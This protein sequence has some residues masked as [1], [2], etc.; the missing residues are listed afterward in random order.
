MKRY[1]ISLLFLL[2]KYT[3]LV[4]THHLSLLFCSTWCIIASALGNTGDDTLSILIV[5]AF[6]GCCSSHW[7]QSWT[8]STF[9]KTIFQALPSPLLLKF[10]TVANFPVFIIL[11]SLNSETALVCLVCAGKIHHILGSATLSAS[12]TQTHG[13]TER[14]EKMSFICFIHVRT[15]QL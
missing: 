11:F 2:F 10:R 14:G 12:Q 3:L 9:R 15:Q 6:G 1:F 5:R 7:K 13:H 8:L 4:W